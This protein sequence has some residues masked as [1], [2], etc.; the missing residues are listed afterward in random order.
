MKHQTRNGNIHV[1]SDYALLTTMLLFL[2]NVTSL[3]RFLS[4]KLM[5]LTSIKIVIF[6]WHIISSIYTC[7][8][9]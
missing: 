7:N 9:V 5:N 4:P 3:L 6:K 1:F 8:F 2:T